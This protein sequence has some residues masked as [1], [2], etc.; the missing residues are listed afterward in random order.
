MLQPRTDLQDLPS[1]HNQHSCL[2]ALLLIP[3]G[4]LKDGIRRASWVQGGGRGPLV[5]N[6]LPMQGDTG[7]IPG[8]G[9]GTSQGA[10]QLSLC[11]V[12]THATTREAAARDPSPEA[13]KSMSK[14]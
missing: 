4:R 14:I 13:A 7:S 12:T 10:G 9:T 2:T 5:K 8:W 6:P 3:H 1:E 11:T